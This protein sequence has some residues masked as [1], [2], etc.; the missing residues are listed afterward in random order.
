MSELL[1]APPGTVLVNLG[2]SEDMIR[3]FM[4]FILSELVFPTVHV[5]S[6]CPLCIFKRITLPGSAPA[7]ADASR[8]SGR[9]RVGP[10][11]RPIDVR[12]M[13]ISAC[14]RDSGSAARPPSA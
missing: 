6:G 12:S 11:R 3:Y 13:S 2:M 4:V 14:G 9:L 8:F 1:Y 7:E 5:H 10:V